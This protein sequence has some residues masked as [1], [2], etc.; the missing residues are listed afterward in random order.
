MLVNRSS[1]NKNIIELNQWCLLHNKQRVFWN[2]KAIAN[3]RE[4]K[5]QYHLKKH[6]LFRLNDY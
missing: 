2:K 3:R 4:R 1:R 5:K 6:Q